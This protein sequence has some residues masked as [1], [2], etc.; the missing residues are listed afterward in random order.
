M[1]LYMWKLKI[2]HNPEIQKENKLAD[3]SKLTYSIKF[4]Y[5]SLFSISF[6][7]LILFF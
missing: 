5:D 1:K 6:K 2:F 4:A 3:S 7:K